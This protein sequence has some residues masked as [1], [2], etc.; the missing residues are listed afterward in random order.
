MCVGWAENTG[1]REGEDPKC[2]RWVGSRGALLVRTAT[3]LGEIWVVATMSLNT[4]NNNLMWFFQTQ[5]LKHRPRINVT[6]LEKA[7]RGR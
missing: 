4:R 3:S 6:L 5:I 7:T 1:M 2:L